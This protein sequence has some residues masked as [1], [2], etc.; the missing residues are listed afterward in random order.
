[1]KVF[2]IVLISML[3]F[4][5]AALSADAYLGRKPDRGPT[6]PDKIL[7]VGPDTIRVQT[8]KKA[9][10]KVT[11][12]DPI[13]GDKTVEGADNIVTYRVTQ[14]TEITVDGLPSKLTDVV[15]GMKVVVDSGATRTDAARV[16][17]NTV[18]PPV[19]KATPD[20]HRAK[21]TPKA[22]KVTVKK[23]FRKITEEKVISI[24]AGRITA[25]QNGAAGA[26]AY[27]I[28]PM[29]AITLNGQPAHA[30]DIKPGMSVTIKAAG[31]YDAATIEASD[32]DN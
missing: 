18:P 1:M 8:R 2:N 5:D 11:D 29:T 32:D 25:A 16:V 24:R 14:G 27:F 26:V 13:T 3:L 30:S 10:A 9:G 15:A 20:P 19:P 31:Q 21:P 4:A 17:A 23:P 7:A 28:T 12:I 6:F 22:K